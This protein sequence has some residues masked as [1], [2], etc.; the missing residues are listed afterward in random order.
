MDVLFLS[1]YLFVLT[2]CKC[3]VHGSDLQVPLCV[4]LHG[5]LQ[6]ILELKLKA[7]VEAVRSS[8][9]LL[10]KSTVATLRSENE[11]FFVLV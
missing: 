2:V 7:A 8:V 9:V 3:S 1:S 4:L 11:V 6:D 10:E 5:P